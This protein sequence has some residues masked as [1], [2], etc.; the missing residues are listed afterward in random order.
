MPDKRGRTISLFI[1]AD[2]KVKSFISVDSRGMPSRSNTEYL[3]KINKYSI[4]QSEVVISL[5]F[6]RRTATY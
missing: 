6:V 2:I 3:V 5:K 1:P 4:V